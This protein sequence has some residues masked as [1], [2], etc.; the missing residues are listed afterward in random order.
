MRSGGCGSCGGRGR[1]G[2]RHGQ[3]GYQLLLLLLLLPL[4]LLLP[5]L[6]LQL[7]LLLLLLLRS[8]LAA[9]QLRLL[10]LQKG[11]C[12]LRSD[13]RRRVGLD[14]AADARGEAG[15]VLAVGLHPRL[16]PLLGLGGGARDERAGW[17]GVGR[18][19]GA[20]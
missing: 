17:S 4:R 9:P 13:L 12:C 11:G 7:L 20:E 16:E 19:R 15:H 1:Y 6:L 18:I 2:A 10:V 3:R 8:L 5:R 14:G